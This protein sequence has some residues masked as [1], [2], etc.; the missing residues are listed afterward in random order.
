MQTKIGSESRTSWA[1]VA[2]ALG[3]GLVAAAHVGKLP[4][5]LPAIRA[6]LHLDLISASY[7]A[8][9]FSATGMLIATF[10]GVI[11]DRANQWRLATAGLIVMAVSGFAGSFAGSG[12]Q[13]LVSRFFEGVGFLAVVVAAP[14]L[15]AKA[16]SGR[17]RQMA[18][19]LWPG[20]MPSG[21]TLAVLFAPLLLSGGGWR[22][23]WIALAAVCAGFAALML[24]AGRRTPAP[25]AAKTRGANWASF[26]TALQQ[27]GPWLIAGCFALY[28]AQLYAIITWM[29]TFIIE[30]RGSGAASAASL[31][32]LAVVSNGLSNIL[33]GWLLRRAVAPWAMI[34]GA[35]LAMAIAAIAA[36]S[37]VPD[38]VRY[39]A[40]IAICGAGGLVASASFAAAP[41]FAR[42]PGQTGTINGLL[43]QA[44]NLAQFAG[45]AAVAIG[46]SR[47]GH[48]ESALWLMVGANIAIIVLAL[49]VRRQEKLLPA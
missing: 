46:V 23:L 4:P 44:S 6:D 45:P 36:L 38:V 37:H 22:G 16:A 26:R 24:V 14:S 17:D 42:S 9:L 13:L 27:S 11:A 25:R 2:I 41:Q 49:L 12:G 35:G 33:G 29:P 34:V 32:A 47:W 30:E 8:S 5:A 39:L 43:V 7:L 3:A 18:L 21:V 40:A 10:I 48:W 15:I 31:T 1:V 28:G 20:Y 19:G